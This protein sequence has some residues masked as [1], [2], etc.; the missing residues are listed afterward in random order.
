[1]FVVVDQEGGE[2]ASG[3]GLSD[4]AVAIDKSAVGVVGVEDEVQSGTN[5]DGDDDGS[6]LLFVLQ[7]RCSISQFIRRMAFTIYRAAFFLEG[8]LHQRQVGISSSLCRHSLN[9]GACDMTT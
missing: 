1:M 5:D 3:D 7:P 9:V 8:R 4:S 2:K 6:E